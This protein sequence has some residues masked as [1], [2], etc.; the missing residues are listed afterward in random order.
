MEKK[1]RVDGH[2][3]G[4][5]EGGDKDTFYPSLWDWMVK[6]LGVKTVLDV[7]CGQGHALKEFVR[8]G[9]QVC[10][11]DGLRSNVDDC[12]ASGCKAFV[13][14]LTQGPWTCDP[15]VDLVWCCE[16]VEHIEDKHMEKLLATLSNGRFVAMTHALPGQIGHHHVNCRP[17]S[18]W[19]RKMNG[20]GY[21]LRADL[22]EKSRTLAPSYWAQTGLVF[23][24][25]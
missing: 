22:T 13:H 12:N 6:T 1:F 11:I 2:L 21:D 9:C 18:Y 19:I 14:D 24:K 15:R 23:E 20:V 7:G 5:I 17:S 8:F 4:N 25:S 16:L 10:G 3:G